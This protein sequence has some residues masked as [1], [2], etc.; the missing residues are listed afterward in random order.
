[1]IPDC[2]I[3]TEN[4]KHADTLFGLDLATIRGKT[5]WRKP[6]HVVTDYVDITRALVDINKQVT[7]AVNVMFVNSVPLLVS[8]SHTI[9]LI[10]IEHAP[11]CTAT[12]LGDLIQHIIRVYA[13]AGFTVQTILMNNEFEKLKDNF[14]MLALNIPA[15]SEHVGDIERRIRV[16][17]ER[18]RGLV[19]TL[20]YP[21]LPQQMLIHL[22]HFVTMW[23]KNFPTIN[24]ISPASSPCEI[25]LCHRLSYK[26]HCRAPF[27]AYC[28]THEDNKPTNSMHSRALLTICL[29]LLRNT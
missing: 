12:K 9:N 11:K 23:H 22:I 13:R 27:G 20:P 15:F 3:T 4:I 6:T 28:E 25:I 10:A 2:P 26:Q 29:G 24:G 19:C 21:R 5:V 8:V 1:M 14:P 18:A 16:V 17:K 7:L